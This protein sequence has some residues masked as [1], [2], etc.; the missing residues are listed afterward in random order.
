MKVCAIILA[1]GRGERFGARKTHLLVNGK[2]VWKHAFDAFL[3]HPDVD[4]VGVVFSPDDL[5]LV[6]GAAFVVAGGPTRQSSAKAGLAATSDDDT[7]ILFHDG[8]RPWVSH[9]VISRVIEGCREHGAAAA[10]VPVTD[11]I[12]QGSTLLDRTMLSAMQTPQG[13]RRSD[14]LRAHEETSE[15]FTDDVALLSAVGVHA[16]LVQGDPMNK[17]IT[18]PGD[19]PQSSEQRTG[20]GYDIHPFAQD[21]RPLYL[22][23]VHFENHPGLDGHSDADVL[24][25]AIVDALLGAAG[26]GDIGLHFPNTDPQ[27]KQARSTTFLEFAGKSIYDLGW[28]ILNIDATLVAETPKVMARAAEIR[29]TIAQCCNV[30]PDRVNLKATTN[31]RL[32]SI[33]RSEGIAAMAVASIC[34]QHY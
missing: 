7:I 29:H 27:W 23:G 12:R 34:R 19:L 24:L 31:E 9:D 14:F 16:A 6:E 22:G 25:H 10:A 11:T 20:F 4:R 5:Q 2:P 17:K 3:S 13:G 32:G 21:N 26:L 30:E 18:H 28:R 8:A 33:G 1:A 15:E